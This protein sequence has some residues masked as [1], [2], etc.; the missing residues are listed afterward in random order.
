MTKVLL[1]IVCFSV[2]AS[3]EVSTIL[4]PEEKIPP[5]ETVVWSPL[6]QATWDAMNTSLGGKP[7]K[8][9]PPSELMARL[10]S[11]QWKAEQVLPESGWKVWSGPSTEAFLKQAN[12]EAAKMTGEP[13]GPFTLAS[14]NPKSIACFGLLDREVEFER[15][16]HKSKKAP[17]LFRVGESQENVAFFG[18]RGNLSGLY[19]RSVKVLKHEQNWHALEISCNAGDD[20]LVLYM[21]PEPQDFKTACEVVLGLRGE[22]RNEIT[23]VESNLR[24]YLNSG[25]D[26]RIPYVSL[27]TK[28]DFTDQLIGLRY[29]EKAEDPWLIGRAEQKTRFV[30][31]EKG[32]RVRVVAES[33]ADPFAGTPKLLKP[34]K[35]IYDRPFFVF[36]WRDGA[37]WPYFGV[38]LGDTTALLK[39][40]AEP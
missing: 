33:G 18:V 10:D 30:L 29:Y 14:P 3:A 36:L 1:T 27:D 20:K 15:A 7:T 26:I 19:G 21:P 40:Q 12:A 22:V 11:F 16:F 4:H 31:F 34:R 38:W 39:F 35:F 25:D 9:E 24:L 37:E 8:V 6:F 5:G 17:L 13:E 2:S 28:K 32:A 23:T